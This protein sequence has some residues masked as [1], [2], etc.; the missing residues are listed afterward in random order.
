M[1]D[2]SIKKQFIKI[3]GDKYFQDTAEARLVYSY[4]ATPNFQSLPDAVIMP[5]N[6]LKFSKL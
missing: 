3:V 2:T 5:E 1:L 6:T 4:D